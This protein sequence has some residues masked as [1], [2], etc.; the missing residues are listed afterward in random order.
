MS[1]RHIVNIK[2]DKDCKL[3]NLKDNFAMST[4]TSW[5][6]HNFFNTG[7]CALDT[8]VTSGFPLQRD[9][10]IKLYMFFAVSLNNIRTN[11][12]WNDTDPLVGEMKCNN[13]HVTWLKWTW[14]TLDNK[15]IYLARPKNVFT[16]K[17]FILSQIVVYDVLHAQGKSFPLISPQLNIP[18]DDKGAMECTSKSQGLNIL[19]PAQNGC[20]FE[21]DI[22]KSIWSN[23][24]N[25]VLIKIT[26]V[27]S[28][29]SHS[30]RG[31]NKIATILQTTFWNAF[32]WIKIVLCLFKFHLSVLPEPLITIFRSIK[33]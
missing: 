30:H 3:I 8:P 4:M 26:K 33:L 21:E 15:H 13:A 14:H 7:L 16:E 18:S 25:H 17:P 11:S 12:R 5:H 1:C 32:S 2:Y 24:N 9:N 28:W 19:R 27:W 23:G 10:H 22:F 29:W 6:G 20:H 31:W